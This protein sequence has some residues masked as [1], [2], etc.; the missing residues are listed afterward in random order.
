MMKIQEIKY[1]Q[2]QI[3]NEEDVFEKLKDGVILAKLENLADKN[4]LNEDEL[5][6]GEDLSDEDKNNNVQKVLEAADKLNVPNKLKPGDILKG[7]KKKDQDIVGDIL[8]KVMCPP[9]NIKNNPDT[10]DLI[11]EGEVYTILLN[12]IFPE[13]YYKSLPDGEA[14]TAEQQ[15]AKFLKEKCGGAGQ[16][17]PQLYPGL[18]SVRHQGPAV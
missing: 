16:T 4:A 17:S 2:I 1:Q 8:E 9:E 18:W 7:K 15:E 11:K 3:V 13:D 5:K 10:D 6:T 12:N 14:L